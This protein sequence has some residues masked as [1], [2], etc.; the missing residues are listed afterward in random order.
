MRTAWVRAARFVT[1]FVVIFAVSLVIALP[2][3]RATAVE[4]KGI[5]ADVPVSRLLPKLGDE[6]SHGYL[7]VGDDSART[8][9]IPVADRFDVNW[10]PPGMDFYYAVL[11]TAFGRDMPVGVVAK[12]A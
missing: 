3:G 5:R 8:H 11:F 7:K 12:I 6:D 4:A 10:W 1:A 2:D 9:A